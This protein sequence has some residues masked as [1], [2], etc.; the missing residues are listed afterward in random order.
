MLL[1]SSFVA[2][3]QQP[4]QQI[5]R[6]MFYK[7][8]GQA[9]TKRDM[10]PN[11]KAFFVFFD[12]DCEHCQHAMREINSQYKEFDNSE[13]YLVTL[14]DSEKINR[15]MS[16]YG[17]NLIGKRNVTILRDPRNEFINDFKPRQYPSMLL[18]SAKGKLLMYQDDPNALPQIFK[19]L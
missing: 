13:I 18:F 9:F 10:L 2:A 8:G 12:S 19:L 14:D 15:F 11:K 16:A 5:P 17:P 7:Q 3:A 1:L 6:F 4:I